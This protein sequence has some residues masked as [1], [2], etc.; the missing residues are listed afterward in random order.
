MS[1]GV[2]SRN[3]IDF[4]D[5][6][7][8]LRQISTPPAIAARSR[9][10]HSSTLAVSPVEGVSEGS[11]P[12]EDA[13]EDT[14]LEGSSEDSSPEETASDDSSPAEGVSAGFSAA[15]APQPWQSPHQRRCSRHS[16]RCKQPARPQR[17]YRRTRDSGVP[18]YRQAQRSASRH[19]P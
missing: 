8:A 16:D 18:S 6:C 7:F 1:A 5:Y 10:P 9:P 15:M 4:T 19:S 3:C 14:P 12:A 13:S 2:L 17:R 11:S